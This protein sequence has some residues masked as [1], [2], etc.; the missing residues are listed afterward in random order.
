MLAASI[1]TKYTAP[2]TIASDI[3]HRALPPLVMTVEEL[4]R[5]VLESPDNADYLVQLLQTH[6]DA[7]LTFGTGDFWRVVVDGYQGNHVSAEKLL[8]VLRERVELSLSLRR[9][10]FL[11]SYK[12]PSTSIPKYWYRFPDTELPGSAQSILVYHIRAFPA[13]SSLIEIVED[14]V[15]IPDGDR[16]DIW[17]AVFDHIAVNRDS[18]KLARRVLEYYAGEERLNFPRFLSLWEKSFYLRE[19]GEFGKFRR[20]QEA[21]CHLCEGRMKKFVEWV[22]LWD[23]VIPPPFDQ[24]LVEAGK[25]IVRWGNPDNVLRDCYRE[26]R[27]RD[28]TNAEL[29]LRGAWE[30]FREIGYETG[31]VYLARGLDDVDLVHEVLDFILDSV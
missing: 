14:K 30:G 27:E 29:I 6:S 17:K 12:F 7:S 13:S 10:H 25:F 4:K 28:S 24:E 1:N 5:A 20:L 31:L 21:L 9:L 22:S 16:L 11:F 15:E 8:A 18:L 26:I 2:V 19:S 3:S 23:K